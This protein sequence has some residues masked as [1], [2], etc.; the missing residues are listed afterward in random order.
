MKG[1]VISLRVCLVVC[2]F[3]RIEKK[4]SGEYERKWVGGCLVERGGGEKSGGANKFSLPCP[5]QNTISPNW[6]ENWSKKWEKYLNK[7]VPPLLTF[8]ASFFFF[9]LFL[10]LVT[11]A[12]C[13]CFWFFQWRG[14]SF[15]FSFFFF[16]FLIFFWRKNFWMIS[17]AIF[18]NVHFHL[19]TIYISENSLNDL[20]LKMHITSAH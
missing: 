4:K 9:L 20:D 15:F 12:F 10:S 5:L 16:N 3:G 14:G 8:L 17:Y 11:L 18:W 7:T 2:I 19:Y 6:R 1:S 13:F